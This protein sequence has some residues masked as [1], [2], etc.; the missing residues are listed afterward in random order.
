MRSGPVY[1]LFTV[2]CHCFVAHF[3]LEAAIQPARGEQETDNQTDRET[4][5]KSDTEMKTE[6]ETEP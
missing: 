1:K 2:A 6:T 5:R 4:E 3:Q